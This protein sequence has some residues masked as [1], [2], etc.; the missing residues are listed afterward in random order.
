M[1]LYN[2]LTKTIDVVKPL[3]GN[4]IRMYT[5]GPT[6]YDS[7]HIG[8][9]SSYIFADTLKRTLKSAGFKVE[10]VMN[11]TDVDDKTIKRS[12][13]MHPDQRLLS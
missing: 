1:K 11:F 12:Q 13:E 7:A 5:C 6:V 2:S 8:N 4:T 10:H 3:E 9:L